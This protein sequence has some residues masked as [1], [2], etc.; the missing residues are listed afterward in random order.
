MQTGSMEPIALNF[1]AQWGYSVHSPAG[2]SSVRLL[3]VQSGSYL[4]QLPGFFRRRRWSGSRHGLTRDTRAYFS[5]GAKALPPHTILQ[6]PGSAGQRQLQQMGK[7]SCRQW[8]EMVDAGD[9]WARPFRE[10][11]WGCRRNTCT[12]PPHSASSRSSAGYSPRARGAHRG[13]VS[14]AR[15]SRPGA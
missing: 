1:L 8:G 12:Q 3:D 2:K 10:M 7:C 13:R 5:E 11:C 15:G 4:C 6:C 9:S 14:A